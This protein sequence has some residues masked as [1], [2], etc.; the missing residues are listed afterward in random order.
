MKSFVEGLD[1]YIEDNLIV[2]TEHFLIKRGPCCGKK[3]KNCPYVDN[4][5]GSTELRPKSL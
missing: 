5:K 3:C 4:I 1:Y 2:F